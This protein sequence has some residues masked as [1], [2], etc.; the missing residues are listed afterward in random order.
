MESTLSDAYNSECRKG[1]LGR[2][3]GS[4]NTHL[5]SIWSVLGPII[6]TGELG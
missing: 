4:F 6:G 5:L 2:Q 1:Y 3:D